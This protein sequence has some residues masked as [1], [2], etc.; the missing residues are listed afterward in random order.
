VSRRPLAHPGLT[1][2]GYGRV[3]HRARQSSKNDA[4]NFVP[5][6]TIFDGILHRDREAPHGLNGFLLLIHIGTSPMRTDKFAALLGE[7]LDRLAERGHQF[8]RVDRL[9]QP[10]TT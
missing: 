7:L 5:S 8:V 6:R 1:E 2:A 3:R 10:T 9:I 4:P